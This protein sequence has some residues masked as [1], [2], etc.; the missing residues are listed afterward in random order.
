MCDSYAQASLGSMSASMAPRRLQAEQAS[1]TSATMPL[2]QSRFL[3]FEVYSLGLRRD[4]QQ[5]HSHSQYECLESTTF[6]ICMLLR[7][8]GTIPWPKTMCLQLFGHLL[9]P[10]CVATRT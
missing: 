10:A 4:Q 9:F 8:F 7:I 5:W 6:C 2:H 1:M 3:R